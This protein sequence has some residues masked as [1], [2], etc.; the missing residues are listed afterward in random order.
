[1]RNL[2]RK[3][4]AIAALALALIS[5]VVVARIIWMAPEGCSF[6]GNATLN[7]WL[8]LFPSLLALCATIG[9]IL[10]P[11]AAWLGHKANRPLRF[12][13]LIT[14]LLTGIAMHVLL[15]GAYLILLGAAYR[16]QF[17]AMSFF[18]PQPFVAGALVGLIYWSVLSLRKSCDAPA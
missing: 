17:L 1:M 7:R 6:G 10:L 14:P 5:M 3:S 2:S 13:P 18:I 16:A 4:H 9:A 15:I 11:F 8:C 12:G